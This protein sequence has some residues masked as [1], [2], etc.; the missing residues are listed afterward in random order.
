MNFCDNCGSLLVQT[1]TAE[2]RFQC[3]QC[4]SEFDSKPEDTLINTVASGYDVGDQYRNIILN[5]PYIHSI[6]KENIPCTKCKKQPVSYIRIEN[7]VKMFI[8]TC[9][10]YWK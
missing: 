6:P 2:L 8:C 3:Y 5:T 1:T 10:H 7:N 4:K 9:G